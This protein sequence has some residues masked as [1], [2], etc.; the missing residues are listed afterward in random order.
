MPRALATGYWFQAPVQERQSRIL[1]TDI[2]DHGM[3]W[4]LSPLRLEKFVDERRG[5]ER[6]TEADAS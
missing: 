1:A 5:I 3:S 6:A 2:T 4:G